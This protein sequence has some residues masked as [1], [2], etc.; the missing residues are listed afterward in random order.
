MAEDAPSFTASPQLVVW[1]LL[2][3]IASV[4]LRSLQIIQLFKVASL[5]LMSGAYVALWG[6]SVDFNT[7]G[8]STETDISLGYTNTLKLS[9][10]LAPTYDVGVIRYGYIGSGFKNSL[11]HTMVTLVLTL[12]SFTEN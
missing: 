5:S 12:P 4:V 8:V 11:F 2:Q 9:D 3:I 6:S 1:L 10:T 7:P